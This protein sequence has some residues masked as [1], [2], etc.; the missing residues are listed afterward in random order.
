MRSHRLTHLTTLLV[1]KLSL[2]PTFSRSCRSIQLQWWLIQTSRGSQSLIKTKKRCVA[3]HPQ[4]VL[5]SWST[6][7]QSCGAPWSYCYSP[8]TEMDSNVKHSKIEIFQTEIVVKGA[9]IRDKFRRAS[10][11]GRGKGSS[12]L[13]MTPQPSWTTSASNQCG[14]LT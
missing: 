12:V 10:L 6:E 9:I 13:T 1:T 3:Y 5:K 4:T 2:S 7:L 11:P 14:I 8:K